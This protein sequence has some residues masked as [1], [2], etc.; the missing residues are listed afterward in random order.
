MYHY[1]GTQ[2][3]QFSAAE[4]QRRHGRSGPW[5]RRY[6]GG[7]GAGG[8]SHQ[9]E[10]ASPPSWCS[11]GSAS[12]V[13]TC[14]YRAFVTA[15]PD[16]DHHRYA[17]LIFLWPTLV[18]W[19]SSI[20]KDC[21]LLFTLGIASL[22]AA[23]VLV[24]RPRRVHRCSSIGLAARQLRA[25]PRRRCSSWWRSA[26]RCSSVGASTRPGALTPAPS[27]R[28]PGWSCSSLL[29][30]VSRHPHRRPPQRQRHQRAVDSAISGVGR[31]RPQGGSAFVPADPPNPVG[32]VKAAVTDP[33]PAVPVRG[34]RH[35]SRSPRRLRRCSCSRS[36]AVLVV[37]P[38][39][40]SRADCDPIPTSR[41]RSSYIAD[42]SSSRSARSATSASWRASDHR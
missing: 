37:A 29:G 24:R 40:R 2:L 39:D 33:V 5:F 9:L 18:F 23:R 38:G 21:W 11:R 19:P 12:S 17:L 3:A 13:A 41:S 8:T 16:A 25:A 30:A 7:H 15:L 31:A 36:D 22:G 32:Y 20:G 10:L 27:A 35:S 14:F 1:W 28:S 6:A 42:R 26:S 34:P 4:L